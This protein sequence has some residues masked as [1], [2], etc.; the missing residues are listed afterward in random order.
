MEDVLGLRNGEYP[1]LKGSPNKGKAKTV[2][3]EKGPIPVSDA[4]EVPA[5]VAKDPS[6]FRQFI[7]EQAEKAK[8]EGRNWWPLLLLLPLGL[9]LTLCS[10]PEENPVLTPVK[11]DDNNPHDGGH[12]GGS[13]DD[14]ANPTSPENITPSPAPQQPRTI[15][16]ICQQCDPNNPLSK[17]TLGRTNRLKQKIKLD[18]STRERIT[19]DYMKTKKYQAFKH[20]WID[21][22]P[23]NQ[24]ALYKEVVSYLHSPTME[25]IQA[26]QRCINMKAVDTEE[27]Q[28]GILGRRTLAAVIT[29]LSRECYPDQKSMDTTKDA[30][31]KKV[32]QE[33]PKNDLL[34]PSAN[35][36]PKSPILN[37]ELGISF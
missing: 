1:G 10:G 21:T 28:D 14:N 31:L 25:N 22:P 4:I 2:E 8:K 15:E 27:G 34:D 36:M 20:A 12:D 18:E 35:S 7:K 9:G 19:R 16:E 13:W 23:K 3:T 17:L 26:M 33:Y 32:E 6:K 11:P 37:P 24:T 29:A 30:M 5:D